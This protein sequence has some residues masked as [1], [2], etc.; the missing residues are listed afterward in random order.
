MKK[1]TLVLTIIGMMMFQSCTREEV[2]R[3]LQDNDTISE[4]FEVGSVNFNP[5]NNFSFFGTLNPPI[6]P[7]DKVL[8]YRLSGVDGNRD[9]WR[10]LPQNY[11]FNNGTLSH[12]YN[13]DFTTNDFSIFMEGFD[14][15]GL[16]PQWIQN[17]VFRVVIIPAFSSNFKVDVT[18]YDAVMNHLGL[19]EDDVKTLETR[20]K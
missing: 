9:V 1:I 11:F 13:F 14:L 20:L 2:V 7:S 4:V 5:F 17:Q 16:P 19:T 3:D 15:A 18:N 10:L 8:I 6:F 12:S